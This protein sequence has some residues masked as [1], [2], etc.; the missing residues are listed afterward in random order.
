MAGGAIMNDEQLTAEDCF[1]ILFFLGVPLLV[2][3]ASLLWIH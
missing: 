1:V 2:T 3:L